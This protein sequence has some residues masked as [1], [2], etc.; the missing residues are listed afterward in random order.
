M[1]LIT[2][3][4]GFVRP[5]F[6]FWEFYSKSINAPEEHLLSSK[7]MNGW[8]AV[9]NW[10]NSSVGISSTLRTPEGNIIA[11]GGAAS[12]HLTGNAGDGSFL[13]NQFELMQSFYVEMVCKGPL[14][15]ELRELGIMGIGFYNTFLHLDD[16]ESPLNFRS[17]FTIWDESNGQYGPIE[18]S[19]QYMATI[20]E[21][22]AG[23]YGNVNCGNNGD[24]SPT[25]ETI[26]SFKK[27][28]G[29]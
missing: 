26:Q 12:Q 19:S 6:Q 15:F 8:Q 14:Y 22:T 11:G 29:F 17:S 7:V 18:L 13:E 25:D 9:R 2:N 24:F 1:E 23:N 4:T 27:K 5:N 20:P 21:P 10:A 3:S 28:R 16:G